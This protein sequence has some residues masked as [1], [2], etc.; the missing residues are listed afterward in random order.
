MVKRTE[1]LVTSDILQWARKSA[2]YSV[3][4]QVGY[5]PAELWGLEFWLGDLLGQ[6]T[7]HNLMNNRQNALF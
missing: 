3:D 4:G 5:C 7:V 2:D 1:A 6:V